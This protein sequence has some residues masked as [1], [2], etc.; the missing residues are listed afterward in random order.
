MHDHEDLMKS[1]FLILQGV[2]HMMSTQDVL[3][4]RA[5]LRPSGLTVAHGMS[6]DQ[7]YTSSGRR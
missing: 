1:Y 3:H 2:H 7:Y 6:L 4:P 5:S